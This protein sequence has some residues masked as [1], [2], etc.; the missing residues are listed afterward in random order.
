MIK[1]IKVITI[2]I[3][4]FATALFPLIDSLE[5]ESN[6]KISNDKIEIENLK[7]KNLPSTEGGIFNAQSN[8]KYA[9]SGMSMGNN[10]TSIADI[11]IYLP[12]SNLVK[13]NFQTKY[14][15]HNL[16]IGRVLLS[17]DGG[18]NFYILEQVMGKT[19]DWQG[20]TYDITPWSGDEIILRFYYHSLYNS[21]G[22]G[23]FI[24]DI[25]LQD[26]TI[27]DFEEYFVGNLWGDWIITEGDIE[28]GERDWIYFVEPSPEGSLFNV[29][30]KSRDTMGLCVDS[31]FYGMFRT[32][33][34]VNH[35]LYYRLSIPNAG[36]NS[37][38]GKPNVPK[39][40]RFFEVPIG[41]NINPTI[42]YQV[43]DIL[44]GYNVIP[45][46]EYPKDN[47]EYEIPPFAIDNALYSTNAFYPQNI[48]TVEGGSR[49]NP[50]IIRGVRIIAL[51]LFP[52]QFNPV[53]RE[54]K[55]YSK[56]E[57]RLEYDSP[58][59]VEP[60]DPRL[61]SEEFEKLRQSFILNYQYRPEFQEM[62][63]STAT[64][65]RYLII[66]HDDFYDE[67]LPLA[68]WKEKKGLTTKIVKTSEIDATGPSA[69]DISNYIQNAYKFW[70]IPPTYVVLIGDH[71]HIPAHTLSKSYELTDLYHATV[72]GSD[73]FAD[74]FIGRISVS[75]DTDATTIVNKILDYERNPPIIA[76]Y[77]DNVTIS[78]QFQDRLETDDDGDVR[79]QQDGYENRGF[80]YTSETLR[81]HLISE[82]YTV[83]RIY[84]RDP[85][86]IPIHY[87]PAPGDS[88][89]YD[90]GDQLP[91]ALRPPYT[92]PGVTN[93]I[94]DAFQN[95]RFLM[96]HR[97]HGGSSGWSHPSFTTTNINGLT[98]GNLLPVVYSTNCLTG[99]F[100]RN[101]CFCEAALRKQNGGA[102]GLIGATTG[103]SSP[104][105]DW[106]ARGLI[107][108]TWT[109]FDP[110]YNT[111]RIY[112]LG[113]IM[114]F[115]KAYMASE[116]DIHQEH[117]EIY[118]IFG[119]PEMEIW[120]TNPSD[121]DITHPSA[122]SQGVTQEFVV[123]VE[124]NSGNDINLAK[125]CLRK[126]S[127]IY[128]VEETNPAGEAY[129]E[130]TPSTTGDIEITV[131]KHDFHPYEG[132]IAVVS[133]SATITVNPD[134][135]PIGSTVDLYG[136]G[137]Q[138]DE[139][140]LITFPDDIPFTIPS[141]T[142]SFLIT[143]YTVPGGEEGYI[144]IEAIG[145]TSGR[146]AVTMF[147]KLPFEPQ[148]GVFT[149]DQH[150]SST[151]HLNPAGDDPVW[152]SPCIILYDADTG[153]E[154][155]SNNLEFGE[156]YIIQSWVYNDEPVEAPNTY[157]T[158]E[159]ANFGGG[160]ENIDW[161][162]YHQEIITVPAASSF[163]YGKEKSE[164]LYTPP[165]TGHICIRTTIFHTNDKNY[166][167]NEGQENTHVHPV[168][169]PG[170][171]NFNFKNP[172]TD[173]ALIYLEARQ[174]DGPD[175][176]PARITRIHPQKQLPGQTKTVTFTVDV[177]GGI[178]EGESRSYSITGY[179]SGE[180]IGGIQVKIQK[181]QFVID[182]PTPSGG[183]KI[184]IGGKE[185][186]FTL[187]FIA[188]TLII[189]KIDI[190]VDEDDKLCDLESIDIYID[191]ELMH[192]D[193]YSPFEWEWSKRYLGAKHTIKVVGYD[194]YQNKA[195]KEVI[196]RRFL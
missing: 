166:D 14:D 120:T 45:G 184:Y 54:V 196:V 39:I 27:E 134:Y 148:N 44:S 194:Q 12:D 22:T 46:Q 66:T 57:V 69:N 55:V 41:V 71:N 122:I 49:A 53:T 150:E 105:N 188:T 132:I 158:Y 90:N 129:F 164:I 114:N 72:D 159:W 19:S 3:L 190:V 100:S 171:F 82:G 140:I 28:P 21:A 7:L 70:D 10:L 154:V 115:G 75:N 61:T 153:D 76:G 169:S 62:L 2:G 84:T 136:T 124:D 179:I 131:T 168:S 24:D 93:D 51:N 79:Y 195:E 128:K 152:D 33:A 5:A 64:G 35:T 40:T 50:I 99:N 181:H 127:E 192:S 89:T 180:V 81:N 38:L 56:I 101:A 109:D 13:L 189:G 111:G 133:G 68:D 142:G 145:Q 157:V 187:P 172:T 137:F 42:I 173:Y 163:G 58:A 85:G 4:L 110:N 126:G 15:I 155:S 94:I 87:S 47:E 26:E 60:I 98:N 130:V 135:G 74:L 9:W 156:N 147:R 32:G 175:L 91:V 83:D 139:I 191:D 160:Q 29:I 67:I 125:V 143:S 25:K 78:S 141:V 146:A 97:D 185:V 43:D 23:W 8:G 149:Y 123:K 92:W 65:G 16:D 112:K 118:H 178:P 31:N 138:S 103:S 162:Y 106:F 77:Y 151:Y 186:G 20:R 80:V 121:L 177:P 73:F 165:V 183:G 113:P 6:G 30:P 102:V 108:A 17:N 107:D 170:T 96:I 86:S 37:D 116:F 119:C 1:K 167:D 95:G 161:N 193:N 117:F 182:I 104:H 144:N 59:Q 52:V 11:Y 34:F 174:L 88:N 36:L 48:A 18:A 63:T 176:W